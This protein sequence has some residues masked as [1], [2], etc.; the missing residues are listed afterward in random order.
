MQAAKATEA[1]VKVM[2]DA[3]ECR[4]TSVRQGE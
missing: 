3:D 2:F 4:Y 1:S